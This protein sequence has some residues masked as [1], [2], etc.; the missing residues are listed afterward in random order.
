M[1]YPFDSVVVHHGTNASGQ[2]FSVDAFL[3]LPLSTRL[4]AIFEQR[5]EFFLNGE[6]VELQAALRALRAT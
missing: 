6:R 2:S 4:R 3:A 5:V 1:R